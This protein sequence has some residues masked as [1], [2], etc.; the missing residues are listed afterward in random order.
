MVHCQVRVL[1][2]CN[3]ILLF[4]NTLVMKTIE[5]NRSDFNYDTAVNYSGDSY[6]HPPMTAEVEG[7]KYI[8]PFGSS[9][10]LRTKQI[11]N[12]VIIIGEN[13][14]LSYISCVVI[15]TDEEITQDVF[16][17]DVYEDEFTKNIFDLSIDDQYRILSEYM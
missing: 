14:G 3:F 13:T 6:Y 5:F 16:I 15:D 8:L 12:L 11:D 4:I 1:T 7:L 10:K 9:D 2:G 17:N